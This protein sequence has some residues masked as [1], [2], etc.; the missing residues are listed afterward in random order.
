M[1]ALRIASE[2]MTAQRIAEQV[3]L[4][5]RLKT[6]SPDVAATLLLRVN[7]ALAKMRA[8]GLASEARRDGR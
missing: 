8:R 3:V 4:D 5:R 7:A 2:P 6:E 1:N